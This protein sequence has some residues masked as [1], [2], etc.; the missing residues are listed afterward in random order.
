MAERTTCG[1]IVQNTNIL[2]KWSFVCRHASFAVLSHPHKAVSRWCI[3]TQGSHSNSLQFHFMNNP[4]LGSVGRQ[5]VGKST[6]NIISPHAIKQSWGFRILVVN[7]Q[8]I[9]LW[10]V[11]CDYLKKRTPT[12]PWAECNALQAPG[13]SKVTPF[14]NDITS[15]QYQLK[16]WKWIRV[17]GGGGAGWVRQTLL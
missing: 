10:R 4:V 7:V 2:M 17:G 9:C 6:N 5:A 13:R 3:I 14:I 16:P 15:A 8:C 11:I 12:H 1:N